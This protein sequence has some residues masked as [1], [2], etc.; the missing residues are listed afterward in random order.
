[1]ARHPHRPGDRR[2]H[3]VVQLRRAF[4]VAALAAL[5]ACA[6]PEEQLRERQ[7]QLD[8]TCTGYG[9]VRGT[10]AYRD[11]WMKVDQ[12]DRTRPVVIVR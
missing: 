11:C 5:A 7:A 2:P 6:T 3:G 9:F 12:G 1:M 4:A 8:A 10:D